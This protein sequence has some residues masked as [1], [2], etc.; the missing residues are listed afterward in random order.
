MDTHLR[1]AITLLSVSVDGMY[2]CCSQGRSWS[3]LVHLLFC[4]INKGNIINVIIIGI[5]ASLKVTTP[6]VSSIHS[7]IHL[8]TY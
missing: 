2:F 7:L 5:V 1:V 4:N 8:L 6:H 3:L